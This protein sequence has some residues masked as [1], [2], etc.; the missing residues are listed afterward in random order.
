MPPPTSSPDPVVT[1][2]AHVS[3]ASFSVGNPADLSAWALS[4]QSAIMGATIEPDTAVPPFSLPPM[5][6]LL[7]GPLVLTQSMEDTDYV[8]A[9]QHICDELITWI[10]TLINPTPVVG[11]HGTFTVPAPGAIM[12]T[13]L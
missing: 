10:K 11:T 8:S 13:I 4:L 3:F 7:T 5:T 1:F 6:F 9:L 2:N 12:T